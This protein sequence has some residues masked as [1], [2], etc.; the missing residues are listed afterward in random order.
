[1]EE[2]ITIFDINEYLPLD[3]LKQ[4]MLTSVKNFSKGKNV[5]NSKI[6]GRNR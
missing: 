5:D 3:D 2:R 4:I 1:M 6:T